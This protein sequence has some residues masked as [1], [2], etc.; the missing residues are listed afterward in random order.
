MSDL[1]GKTQAEILAELGPPHA[2]SQWD[3]TAPEG[4]TGAELAAWSARELHRIWVYPGKVV[5]FSVDGRVGDVGDR[6]DL[7]L[8]PDFPGV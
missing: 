3:S 6:S 4:L 8:P 7:Y 1:I 5:S 2:V